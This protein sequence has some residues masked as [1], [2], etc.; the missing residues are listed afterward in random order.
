MNIVKQNVELTGI[1]WNHSRGYL[2][3]V[4][5]AQRFRELHPEVTLRWQKRSLQKFADA[6]L[7]D[8]AARFDLLIIDHPSIGEAASHGL[9]L[10]LDQYLSADFLADQA[11]NTVGH[12][13]ASYF[14]DGHQYALAIDAATPIAGWRPDLLTRDEVTLPQSWDDLLALAR[15]G[16]VTVPAVPIDCL[17]HWFMF[18]NALDVEPFAMPDAVMPAA[19]GAEALE[20][21]RELVGLSAPGSLERNPIETWQFLAESSEI[22]YCPFAYGY[23]NYSRVGYATHRLQSG[24]LVTFNDK[25]FRSTLGGAGLAISRHT[26]HPEQALAYVQY[27]ASAITQR[28]LYTLSGGQPGHRAAWLDDVTNALTGNFFRDTLPTLDTA[29][30]RP[31]FPGFITFQ[32]EASLLVHRHVC[33]GGSAPLAVEAINTAYRKHY[34]VREAR[35]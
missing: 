4:A 1:T 15:R 28:T 24:G 33:E 21:L 34:S 12:S 11:S 19:A 31:R 17:M 22:A 29:W 35:A 7:A 32:D 27:T 14:Y 2:P 23:S 10:P 6:P 13:H 8:L 26:K 20:M 3:V 5:T 25:P 18:A 30:V 16:M 9:L